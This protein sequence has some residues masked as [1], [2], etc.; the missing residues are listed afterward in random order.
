M[1]IQS[2]ARSLSNLLNSKKELRNLWATVIAS[3]LLV[4]G[5][6]IAL[7]PHELVYDEIYYID[8]AKNLAKLGLSAQFISGMDAPTGILYAILHDSVSALTNF[9]PPWIRFV[10][11]IL[12][13]GTCYLLCKIYT[14][15][16][17]A[18][19]KD[20]KNDNSTGLA[21]PAVWLAAP[22]TG[23]ILCMALTELSAIFFSL[24]GTCLLVIHSAKQSIRRFDF[25]LPFLAGISYGLSIWG[26]QNFVILPV[27]SVILLFP[28][29][30]SKL[31]SYFIVFGISALF[32]FV[33]VMIWGGLV[34][35]SVGFVGRGL[36]FSSLVFSFYYVVAALFLAAPSIFQRLD[37]RSVLV[38][39][40]IAS[41]VIILFPDLIIVPGAFYITK[42]FGTL[43]A[44]IVGI[45][46]SFS[47]LSL[48]F[49]TL[50]TII[51]K[52]F[53]DNPNRFTV[54]FLASALILLISNIKIT[55]QFSSRYITLALP[56]ILLSLFVSD[57]SLSKFGFGRLA[58]L[59]IA[60]VVSSFIVVNYY[61]AHV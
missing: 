10:N 15:V 54:F 25:I 56:Y 22:V 3:L 13:C 58:L 23:V 7:S 45:L 42:V 18:I 2:A 35:P 32:F 55:H 51:N 12:G 47:L 33:P 48:S 29:N 24:L 14:V 59:T 37:R 4:Y 26:R 19:N 57:T 50:Q 44:F 11:L 8:I 39:G 17:S 43:G 34:P 30:S 36:K 61:L 9:R 53:M 27:L 60:G 40:L 1:Q 5:L 38:S 46:F 52:I 41:L 20:I 28:L 21:I 6:L 49:I 16:R 31:R